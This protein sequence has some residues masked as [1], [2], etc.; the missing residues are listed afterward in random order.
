MTRGVWVGYNTAHYTATSIRVRRTETDHVFVRMATSVELAARTIIAHPTTDGQGLEV[1]IS[2]RKTSR[3]IA[4]Q[5][6]LRCL[7]IV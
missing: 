1:G 5:S 4:G 3:G 2:T 7:S 6:D